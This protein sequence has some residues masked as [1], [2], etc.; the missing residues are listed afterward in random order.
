MCCPAQSLEDGKY[1]IKSLKGGRFLDVPGSCDGTAEGDKCPIQLFGRSSLKMPMDLSSNVT[2]HSHSTKIKFKGKVLGSEK[3]GLSKQAQVQTTKTDNPVP[4]DH[5]NQRWLVWKITGI[6][7]ILNWNV[8]AMNNLL[9]LMRKNSCANNDGCDVKPA[10]S[11]TTT[12]HKYGS[13]SG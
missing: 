11:M 3:A 5:D 6:N 8:S 4:I 10:N 2:A 7:I 12:K 1:T 13:F 9:A